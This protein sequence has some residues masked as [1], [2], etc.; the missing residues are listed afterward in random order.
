ML[1]VW[2]PKFYPGL[3]TGIAQ[4]SLPHSS[5]RPGVSQ[6]KDVLQFWLSCQRTREYFDINPKQEVV[7]QAEMVTFATTL[8]QPSPYTAVIKQVSSGTF[9]GTTAQCEAVDVQ[10][11]ACQSRRLR[12]MVRKMKVCYLT[13]STKIEITSH[14][15]LAKHESALQID[16][17]ERKPV[18]GLTSLEK[19]LAETSDVSQTHY[20][21][22]F[23]L[24]VWYA[25]K[26]CK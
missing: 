23:L 21:R 18:R 26:T 22:M 25:E 13:K 19:L 16:Y 7:T 8:P 4:V 2:I 3:P 14:E 9:M 20:R 12:L 24:T 6:L 17:Y 5:A 15:T 11:A 10:G 1:T